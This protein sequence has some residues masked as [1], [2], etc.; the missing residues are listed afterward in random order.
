M[1][2]NC[3]DGEDIDGKSVE[4]DT[5]KGIVF[6]DLSLTITKIRD[7]SSRLVEGTRFIKSYGSKPLKSTLFWFFSFCTGNCTSYFDVNESF[8]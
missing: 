7:I 4:D 8:L 2:Q 6:K 3:V 5:E 1:I